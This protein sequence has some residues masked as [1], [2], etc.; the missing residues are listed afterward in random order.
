MTRKGIIKIP[1]LSG[2]TA[3]FLPL[4][5]TIRSESAMRSWIATLEFSRPEG[6]DIEGSNR[7]I[8]TN[9][10]RAAKH[11]MMEFMKHVLP[12]LYSPKQLCTK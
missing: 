6:V 8:S 7:Q 1:Y 4:C 11:W 2:C 5:R 12:R 3:A 10:G 9:S